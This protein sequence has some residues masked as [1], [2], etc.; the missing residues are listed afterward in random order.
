MYLGLI[1]EC[2][3]QGLGRM[4]QV[5]CEGGR[6]SRLAQ[7]FRVEGVESVLPQRGTSGRSF[8]PSGIGLL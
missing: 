2:V 3:W 7:D 4:E 8:A 1:V 6:C 5:G